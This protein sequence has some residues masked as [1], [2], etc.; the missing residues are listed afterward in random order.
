MLY[1]RLEDFVIDNMQPGRD[2]EGALE[3]LDRMIEIMR[4]ERYNDCSAIYRHCLKARRCCQHLGALSTELKWLRRQHAAAKIALGSEHRETKACQAK[5]VQVE[6]KVA[7][8]TDSQ[9]KVNAGAGIGGG[10][11]AAAVMKRCNHCGKELTS[12]KALACCIVAV[13][14][15]KECQKQ[16]WVSHKLVCKR[17]GGASSTLGSG[18][19]AG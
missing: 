17:G 10:G 1:D 4:E 11:A 12:H 13:Y 16:D 18:A 2:I 19:C 15:S 7:G 3:S 6:C 5:L 9:A 8:C 14:C